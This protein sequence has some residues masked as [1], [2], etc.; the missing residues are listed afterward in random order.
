VGRKDDGE[1]RQGLWGR[2][3]NR[4]QS[5]AAGTGCS[6]G[7]P[8]QKKQRRKGCCDMQIIEIEDKKD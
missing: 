7:Q 4:K 1:Q 5:E 2:L 8:A 6:C 3:V